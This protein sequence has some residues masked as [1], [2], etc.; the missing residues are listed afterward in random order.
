MRCSSLKYHI[1]TGEV[2]TP[3][4][5]IGSESCFFYPDRFP[6]ADRCRNN[7]FTKSFGIFGLVVK[8]LTLGYDLYNGQRSGLWIIYYPYSNFP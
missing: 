7:I 2:A 3:Q 8:K 4:G 6:M 1:Y 5:L